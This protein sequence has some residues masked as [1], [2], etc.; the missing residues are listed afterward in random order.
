MIYNWLYT[1]SNDNTGILILVIVILCLLI[2][3]FNLWKRKTDKFIDTTI[4][5][6]T[7]S[8]SSPTQSISSPTQSISSPTQSISS[9]TQSISSPTQS[10]S[11]PTQSISSPTQSISS[12]YTITNTEQEKWNNILSQTDNN[13]ETVINSL[14]LDVQQKIKNDIL[15]LDS[16]LYNNTQG[17]GTNIQTNNYATI[18]DYATIDSLGKAMTDA[19]G[20]IKT[21]LGYTV[22][23]EQLGNFTQY[24]IPNIHTYDNTTNYKTGMN[25]NT[26]DGTS[27]K[28][29]GQDLK[30][31]SGSGGSSQTNNPVFLQKDF[32]GVANIFAPNIIISNPPLTSDGLPDISFQV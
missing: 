22:L 3:N 31:S 6:P 19:I 18:G 29:Q 26:V 2:I 20:G 8:I 15:Q 12:S 16:T 17:N 13:Q 28:I 1:T 5:S 7:Q 25:P 30:F 27:S 9:P 10:I 4:S 32:T 21:N 11:S 14:P 24:T 23:Q